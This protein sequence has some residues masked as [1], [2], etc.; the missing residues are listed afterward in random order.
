MVLGFYFNHS[1]V[2]KNLFVLLDQSVNVHKMFFSWSVNLN[3]DV[4]LE[5]T[6]YVVISLT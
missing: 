3:K 6:M 5:D 1:V 4:A 2:S